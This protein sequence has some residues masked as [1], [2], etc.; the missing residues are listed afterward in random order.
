M[1]HEHEHKLQIMNV[2]WYNILFQPRY[3]QAFAYI[4][5]HVKLRNFLINDEDEDDCNNHFQ[6][7][8]V[9]VVLY[10]STILHTVMAGARLS[11]LDIQHLKKLKKLLAESK[12]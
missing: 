12:Q 7:D 3:I 5:P 11:E 1:A 4:G 8:F 9:A 6:S 2:P 10:G